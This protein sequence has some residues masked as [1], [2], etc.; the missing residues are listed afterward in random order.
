MTSGRHVEGADA[1]RARLAPATELE[2]DRG[3]ALKSLQRRL[4]EELAR[5]VRQIQGS[6]SLETASPDGVRMPADL[7]DEIQASGIQRNQ[8][9]IASRTAA[10]V[11][12]IRAALARISEGRYGLCLECGEPI[13]RPR[14]LA[15]PEV[16]NC[17]DCQERLERA[18]GRRRV[19]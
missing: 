4:E 8:A 15:M 16:A 19:A 7:V 1:G 11:G 9:A 18:E 2:S 3:F 6:T 10:R 12:A 13:A 17:V 14:L 5:C